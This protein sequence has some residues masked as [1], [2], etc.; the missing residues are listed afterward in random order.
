MVNAFNLDNYEFPEGTE[1]KVFIDGELIDT[2]MITG[3]PQ[4]GQTIESPAITKHLGDLKVLDVSFIGTMVM[5]T[6]EPML[7]RRELI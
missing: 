1:L 6:T 3:E 4:K 5:V 7:K 2:V